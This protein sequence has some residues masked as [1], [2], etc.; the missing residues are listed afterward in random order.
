MRT[1]TSTKSGMRRPKRRAKTLEFHEKIRFRRLEKGLD[2]TEAATRAGVRKSTWNGWE[3]GVEPHAKAAVRVA[4]AL[5]TTA[6]HLFGDDAPAPD[7]RPTLMPDPSTPPDASSASSDA[8][9][10]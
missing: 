10:A 1:S 6:E 9:A 8:R 2:Q 3:H 4:K 5:E 7:E